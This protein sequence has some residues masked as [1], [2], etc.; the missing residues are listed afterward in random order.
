MKIL[1]CIG[2][3]VFLSHPAFAQVPQKMSYQAVIRN[4][5]NSLVGLKPVSMQVSILQGFST[6]VAVYVEKQNRTTNA[7]GLVSMQIGAGIAVAGSFIQIDWSNGPYFIK[8]ET[9]P[10]GGTDYT[11]VGTS[12]ML[13]VPYA[14]FA[15]NGVVNDFLG[16]SNDMINLST[17]VLGSNISISMTK[18]LSFATLGYLI[19]SNSTGNHFH[20]RM[21]AYNKETGSL[22]LSIN[23]INGSS[24]SSYWEIRLDASK[25]NLGEQGLKGLQGDIGLS[26]GIGNNGAKG[27]DGPSG[28]IGLTGLAGTNGL[29]GTNGINGNNG[30]DGLNGAIGLTGLAGTNGLTGTNGING[31]DGLNGVIG[32]T[33]LAGTNGLTGTNGING[34]DGLNGVIGLTGLAGTNGLTGTNG[35]NGV[36]G[37]NGAIGLT[38][39]TGAAGSFT[40][41]FSGDVT[42]NQN[43]TVVD[44]INGISLSSLISGVLKNTTLT[45]IPSIAVASDFPVLNQ[46]TTG[47]ALNVSGIIL[48]MNGGTGVA[49]NNAAS[50]NLPG[51]F[52]ATLITTAATSV[53]L[54]AVGTLYG[55]AAA[56]ISS[57]QLLQS[58]TDGSGTGS[59]VFSASPRF[60]DIPLAPT[61][62]IGNNTT[63]LATTEFVLANPSASQSI[64]AG[65]EITTTSATAVVATGMTLS[66]PAGKYAV[67]FNSQYTLSA[68]DRTG[69]AKIDLRTAYNQL[70]A[71]TVTN[72]S[73]VPAFGGGETL[74]AGVYSNAGACTA[75]GN[76]ILDGEGN[77]NAEFV[78]RFGGA[79][80]TA[81]STNITLINR[82]SVC[83]V[84]WVAEG[85]ISTGAASIIKGTLLSNNGAVTID[86][87]NLEGRLLS[88]VGA[89]SLGASVMI[90]PTGCS[91]ILNTISTFAIFT[92]MGN[93]TNLGV[94]NING[95]IG[96]NS[97]TISGFETST[98]NGN[99]YPP[100]NVASSTTA[101]FGIYQNGVLLPFSERSR[102]STLNLGEVSLQGI[103]T[104]A[105]GEA[106]DIR[107][108]IDAGTIKLQNRIFTLI[109]VR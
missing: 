14:L 31:V 69:Q 94:S 95:D 29:T 44:K 41:T 30:V 52:S 47:S 76:L 48:P 100:S 26:G 3:V 63:Q 86:N 71:K 108:K 106:I 8:I 107:M 36:D 35:I 83:N 103:A 65:T 20:G 18:D 101:V 42:G 2:F 56:S 49:N 89:I 90:I 60:T 98:V 6:G 27:I 40:G 43:A 21:I 87:T 12:E 93:V 67:S 38:G 37:L 84:Y 51:P 74:T 62:A 72:A 50:I 58:L 33:G 85:A 24:S 59:A 70:M 105:S 91:S 4:S 16:S 13:S 34:V 99:I 22:E 1:F 15:L 68:S 73:H 5:D 46:N 28:A 57:A 109:N 61:A 92:S 66:P 39:L 82:A 79:F 77:P 55:T 11:I 102:V 32:L 7:N 104:V 10:N 96:T 80:S 78:F 53:T 64:S 19:V 97:G 88:N 23:E 25:G 75:G 9:D 17:L 81:V 45:G 54:P